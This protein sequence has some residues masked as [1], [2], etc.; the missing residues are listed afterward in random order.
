MLE[1]GFD[2]STGRKLTKEEK[3]KLKNNISAQNVRL[4]KKRQQDALQD[5]NE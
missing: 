1:T 2:P 4:E 5:E 3:A